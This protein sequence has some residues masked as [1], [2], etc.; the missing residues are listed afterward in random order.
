VFVGYGNSGA[1]IALD[2]AEAGIDVTLAIRSPVNIVPRELFGLPIL[3]FPIAEQWL[4]PK[5][6]DIINA[7]AIRLTARLA[8]DGRIEEGG[9]RAL[10][11][12]VEE[13][14]VLLIDIGT[15]AHSRR[16]DQGSRRRRAFHGAGSRLQAIAGRALR[17]GDPRDRVPP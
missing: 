9:Q 12:I 16:A 3:V 2:L 11:S 7:P 1:E 8:C 10:Q 5:A 14:Q 15:L 13:G 17:R 4:P 6:A